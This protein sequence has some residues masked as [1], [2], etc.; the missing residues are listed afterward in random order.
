MQAP[1]SEIDIRVD[2]S[3]DVGR[4]Y[5]PIR[6]SHEAVEVPLNSLPDD[7]NDLIDVLK[8]EYAALELWHRFA[9]RSFNLFSQRV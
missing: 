1:E 6:D 2:T 5:I 8:P 7:P 4:L 3:G 9:V